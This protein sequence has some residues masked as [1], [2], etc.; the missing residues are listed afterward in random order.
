MEARPEPPPSTKPHPAPDEPAVRSRIVRALGRAR[1]ALLWE[2]LWPR[3]VP[4]LLVG[5]LFLL[6]SWFG[7]WIGMPNWLRVGL[8]AA[9]AIA[10]LATLV[11]LFRLRVPGEAAALW[12]VEQATS[13]PHRPATAVLDRLGA[14]HDDPTTQAIWAAHRMRVLSGFGRLKA[15][16]P[17]PGVAR[18][19]PYALRFL[20]ILLLVVGFVAAGAGLGD[21]VTDAFRGSAAAVTAA[22]AAR[23][24]AWAA[25]PDYTGR[26]PIFL[27]GAT[28]RAPGVSVVV[29]EGTEVVVRIGG[30]P[31]ELTV[32]HDDGNRT[33]EVAAVA[34]GGG[35]GPLEHRLVLMG[36]GT[37]AVRAGGADVHAWR[38]DVLPDEPPTIGLVGD[39]TRANNGAIRLT[40]EVGDDYGVVAARAEM[41]LAIV[42]DPAAR[43]LVGPPD[44]PL[45]LPRLGARE[46]EAATTKD[47]TAHPWA[48]LAVRLTLVA[49][50][51]AGQE[52]RSETRALVL[53]VRAFTDALA[54]AIVEQRRTLALDARQAPKVL[55]ALDLLTLAP[56][57]FIQEVAVYLAV[58]TAYHRLLA[59]DTDAALRRVVDY[60]WEVAL[61]IE[62]DPVADAATD[63][64]AAIDA[65]REALDRGANAE[66]LAALTEELRAAMAQ[67]I[68][69]LGDQP[70]AVP[71][72]DV[73]AE[74]VDAEQLEQTIDALR[75]MAE[76]GDREGA[77]QLL[78]R[79]QQMLQNLQATGN[80]NDM[81]QPGPLN[82]AAAAA[83]Q[84]IG[85]LILQ[86]QQL[87][88]ETFTLQQQQN[89][90]MPAPRTDE[91]AR[92]MIEELRERRAQQQA[93]AGALQLRQQELGRQLQGILD[94]MAEGGLEDEEV[95]GL[96][97][98]HMAAA[99]QAL[100][101]AGAGVAVVEQG[102]AIDNLRGG[103]EAMVER[104]LERRATTLE[105]NITGDGGHDPL[106][107]PLPTQ[108]PDFGDDVQVPAEIDRQRA[109]EILDTIRDRLEDLGRPVFEREYLERL[110][111]L[112]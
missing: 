89:E 20:V 25:P 30:E 108:G 59:A 6:V 57:V 78:D 103:A 58:R 52:G 101:N 104:L 75:D 65:L 105:R 109:R 24:D 86:Q 35:E 85:E 79:L 51:A 76:G 47:L 17:S 27:T 72:L 96:A 106:G 38:F 63:L 91:E 100:G 32:W 34:T 73:T 56:E 8:L 33:I 49:R 66:E 19:D 13:T 45:A 110:L 69:A 111:N 50:D 88:E 99:E 92:R 83:I 53:P 22:V 21:R 39:P 84:E 41:A 7:F 94:D 16:L 1:A 87:R 81:Q 11:P 31:G 46:G 107:R 112:F 29:P 60:L 14:Q 95:L 48:G 18:R 36:P 4:P 42:R 61:G 102:L 28:L 2:T 67:F 93:E 37:I 54:R 82:Q 62:D 9:F 3:L 40:Y 10:A 5:A 55:S 74:T 44:M 15:G 68:R 77:R 12:R 90:P 43:S 64:Q 23:V 71:D 97:Q 70:Q 98:G 80:V 26:A